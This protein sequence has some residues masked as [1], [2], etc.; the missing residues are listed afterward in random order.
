MHVPCGA[1]VTPPFLLPVLTGSTAITSLIS[2]IYRHQKSSTMLFKKFPEN[3]FKNSDPLVILKEYTPL[4]FFRYFTLGGT[5]G[6][7][8]GNAIVDLALHDTY[9][10]VAHFHLVLSLGALTSIL[11][12][13]FGFYS[14]I[15]PQYNIVSLYSSQ[16]K[17]FFNLS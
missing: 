12:A 13:F 17:A 14:F 2:H 5:T 9:Y 16:A 7:V 15:L 6:V 8:L 3:F 11:T 1:I 4:I 10:V